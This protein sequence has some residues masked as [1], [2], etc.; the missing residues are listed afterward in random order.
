MGYE[1]QG[2][3]ALVTGANRGIGKAI[4]EGLLKEGAAKVY[5]AVR[6]TSSVAGLV[7]EYGDRV[8]PVEFD[9]TNPNLI[10]SAA[11][12]ASDVSLVVN[13]AGV[14]TSTPALSP[15]AIDSLQFEMETNVG[16]LIRV[17]QAFAPVLKANGGG[18]LVQ[19]NSG[20]SLLNFPQ[21]ATYS[22][23]KAA[24]YSITQALRQLL[25]AQ[26][27]LVVSVHP[28]PIATDMGHEAGFEDIA[29]PPEVVSDAMVEALKSGQFHVF[30]DAM[31]KGIGDAYHSFAENVIEAEMAEG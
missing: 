20:A 7:D 27:T 16:G 14:L 26:G 9:L 25:K 17:A 28:G 5:A 13:N 24:A 4:L 11:E 23:S 18:A 10:E 19:L 31:A 8:V 29:E 1:I 15:E 3:V 12:T 22:A 21:F 30:P 6:D 2:Q